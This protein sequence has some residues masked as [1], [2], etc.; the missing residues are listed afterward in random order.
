MKK[1][2]FFTVGLIL[3]VILYFLLPKI[4]S[5]TAFC[6]ID[7]QCKANTCWQN[8]RPNSWCQSTLT[9]YPNYKCKSK[10]ESIDFSDCNNG[11][12]NCLGN[13]LNDQYGELHIPEKKCDCNFFKCK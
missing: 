10:T 8:G 6:Y 7:N 12:F 3:I 5:E 1:I 9:N 11:D 13:K 2:I 4:Y